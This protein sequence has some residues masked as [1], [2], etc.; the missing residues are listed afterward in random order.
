MHYS[1]L[2]AVIRL[3]R[4]RRTCLLTV[5]CQ[6]CPAFLYLVNEELPMELSNAHHSQR[7]R[8]SV[9]FRRGYG[10]PSGDEKQV[11]S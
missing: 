9:V 2:E 11:G 7:R 4:C 6:Q 3:P 10:Y 8:V 1:T 5:T